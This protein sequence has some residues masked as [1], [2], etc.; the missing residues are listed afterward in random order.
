MKTDDIF[1][2]LTD[3]DDKFIA[4]AHPTE[5]S[6]EQ[7]VS[8]SPVPGKPIWKTLVPIAACLAVLCTAGAFGA[9]Y[10]T[11]RLRSN[12][13]ESGNASP[14]QSAANTQKVTKIDIPDDSEVGF[15]MEEFPAFDFKVSRKCVNATFKTTSE[16]DITLK[17]HLFDGYV[18]DDEKKHI[19]KLYLADID[20][21]GEREIC[22]TI[23]DPKKGDGIM[24]YDFDDALMNDTGHGGY[25]ADLSKGS[26]YALPS[27]GKEFEYSIDVEDGVLKAV[28][29][30]W[31]PADMS[32]PP[33]EIS[34]EPLTLDMMRRIPKVTDF[35]QLVI[36]M[37]GETNDFVMEEFPTYQFTA[38]S[39]KLLLNGV[40]MNA[41]DVPIISGDSIT[42]LFLCDL[43]GDGRREICASVLNDGVES[44]EVVDFANDKAYTLQGDRYHEYQLTADGT[45]LMLVEAEQGGDCR[46]ETREPLSLDMMTPI[47]SQKF[48]QEFSNNAIVA[49]KIDVE[50]KFNLAEFPDKTFEITKYNIVMSD[51]TT[52]DAMISPVI[53]GIDYYL[54]DLNG[55]GKR[56][57]VW[58]V[59]RAP[60]RRGRESSGLDGSA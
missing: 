1:E 30:V 35:K 41:V 32:I 39:N 55:D 44:V 20:G 7:P 21:D 4:A 46:T 13:S 12:P 19:L 45:T 5:Q 8:V 43:N 25:A 50:K 56:E 47:L 24:V 58:V 2:A 33:N 52:P 23:R 54:A 28:K 53:S 22:A 40:A 17:V 31:Q 6:G 10:F 3:I 51:I 26:L 18:E 38:T 57:I 29:T 60:G 59:S 16:T 42:N 48:S 14:N 9:K 34:R 36:P 49:T 15:T 37:T 27:D 11:E